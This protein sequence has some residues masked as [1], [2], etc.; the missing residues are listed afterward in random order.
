MDDPPQDPILDLFKANGEDAPDHVRGAQ[1]TD[2]AG[3]GKDCWY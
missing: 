1:G 3:K 2:R